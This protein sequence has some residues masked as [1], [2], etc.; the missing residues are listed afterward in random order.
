M[1]YKIIFLEKLGSTNWRKLDEKKFN[2][3]DETISYK[4]KSF[5]LNE[6]MYSYIDKK[7]TYIYADFENEKIITFSEKDIGLNAKFLDSFLTTGKRG[8]IGQLL[9]SIKTDMT[10]EKDWTSMIKP[11]IWGIIGA[12]IG[13]LIGKG[14]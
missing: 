14:M 11:F 6:K 8:I 4:K 3:Q 10:K 13:F 1:K 7:H 2:P 9:S 5:I 12:V